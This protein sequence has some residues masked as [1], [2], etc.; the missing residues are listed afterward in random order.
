MKY[1]ASESRYASAQFR[2]C[3]AS[4][5][6]LPAVSLGLWQNFG[7]GD[8]FEVGR[9]IIRRAFDRGLTHFDLANNYGP[10]PGSAEEQFGRMLAADLHPYRDELLIT[11]KAG[12][13][14][15]PGP[16]GVGGSRKYLLASLDASLGRL[17]LDY[18]DIFYHHKPDPAVPLSETAGAL[19]QA[20]RSGRALYAGISN[21]PAELA[22][23]M[24]GLMATT[25]T[26]CVIH[27][28]RYSLLDTTAD[29]GLLDALEPQGIG[30]AAFSPLAQGLLT[31]KYQSDAVPQDAR[32]ARLGTLPPERLTPQV[33]A[34][35]TALA[36]VARRRGQSLAQL[37]LSWVLRSSRVC[38]AIIGARTVEQL[39]EILDFARAGPLSPDDRDAIG[40]APAV[41]G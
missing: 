32:M 8:P 23:E 7:G 20:V 13:G 35:I 34:R 19:D 28:G 30:F 38:T 39:D 16:Y 37:A 24:A 3:G 21:Y 9:A 4:G 14:M 25:G 18:V 36:A 11:T 6:A 5:L 31:G 17:G 12:Y 2:R 27:Q 41:A 29:S 15:W 40:R 1:T 26:P 10:P 33:R 22:L